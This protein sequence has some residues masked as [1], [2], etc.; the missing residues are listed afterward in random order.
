M[1]LRAK[2]LRWRLAPGKFAT[3]DSL[4]AA[5]RLI[6]REHRLVAPR[7]RVFTETV[8]GGLPAKAAWLRG[9]ELDAFCQAGPAVRRQRGRTAPAQDPHLLLVAAVVLRLPD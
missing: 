5:K 3:N 6:G 9:S 1:N 8:G 7:L 2:S 4:S